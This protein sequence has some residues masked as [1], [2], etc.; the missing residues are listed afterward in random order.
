MI[1]VPSYV[2]NHVG[3]LERALTNIRA[4]GEALRALPPCQQTRDAIEANDTI[5]A[6]IERTLNAAKAE[7]PAG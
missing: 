2:R 4:K 6:C 5:A 1:E 7:A 3:E